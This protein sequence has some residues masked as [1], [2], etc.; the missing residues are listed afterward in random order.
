[1]VQ[2]RA[3]K[4]RS[5]TALSF[6]FAFLSLLLFIN[7]IAILKQLKSD[8]NDEKDFALR[9]EGMHGNKQEQEK[10]ERSKK[11]KAKGKP[12]G[13]PDGYFN[14]FPVYYQD[15]KEGFHSNAHCI[16]DN[17]G[18]EAWK[19]RSCH[20]QNLCFDTEDREFVMFTS[21][22]QHK[23]EE[24]LEKPQSDTFWTASSKNTSVSVGGMNP[25]WND[26][27]KLLK[28]YPTLRD[29][30]DDLKS[31]GGYFMLQTDKVLIPW[32][33]MAG[34]NPGHL[35][36]DDFLP[37]YKLITAFD[38]IDKDMVLIRYDLTL[39]MWAGCQRQWEKCRPILKKFLPLLGTHLNMTSSQ[40]DTSLELVVDGEQLSRKSKYVCA[41]NGAA[42]LGYL[43]DHFKSYHGW[44]PDDYKMALN[45]GRGG[46]MY[47][48]RNWMVDNVYEEKR[49]E[50]KISKA[51]YR[52][53]ISS[54]S[55]NK[56]PRNVSFNHLATNIRNRLGHKYELDIKEV[57]L[58]TMSIKEQVQLTADAA[59]FISMCGGG[60]VT[61]MFLPKG[62]SLLL[63]YTAAGHG[64]HPNTP[65]RLDWDLLNN[66]GYIRVH[67]LPKPRQMF[68]KPIVGQ[69]ENGND[70]LDFVL[71]LLDHELDII[72]HFD[73]YK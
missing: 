1:M 34:H 7:Q 25:K 64:R 65:A 13:P 49:D 44:H 2:Q 50:R 9:L 61:S 46:Q 28:W 10:E 63:Y 20:F 52:I 6:L 39:A 16:G 41:P 15:F 48:F 12:S 53:I 42:G 68:L 56:G 33:S 29:A 24:A 47:Q 43:T 26:E 57:V 70:D 38:L 19:F 22:E 60:A 14:H 35:V 71:N 11:T 62:A 67:W 27:H 66:I 51:P 40:N 69:N 54:S 23:L 31:Q 21:P 72:S 59:I 4:T 3:A 5:R 18:E 8:N 32:H 30:N 36:W 37:L 55:S 45:T 17:F 58:N 73:D